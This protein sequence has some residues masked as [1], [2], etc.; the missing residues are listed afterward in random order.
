MCFLHCCAGTHFSVQL[1]LNSAH[2]WPTSLQVNLSHLLSGKTVAMRKMELIKNMQNNS[3]IYFLVKI[4][5][6]NDSPNTSGN[7]FVINMCSPTY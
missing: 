3:Q 7:R 6:S 5:Q 1:A 4:P 2:L